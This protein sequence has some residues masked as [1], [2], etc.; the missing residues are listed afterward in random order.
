MAVA[1]DDEIYIMNLLKNASGIILNIL[2]PP[3]IYFLWGIWRGRHW[4]ALRPVHVNESD[5]EVV[6]VDL[7]SKLNE[8]SLIGD[9]AHVRLFFS[10]HLQIMLNV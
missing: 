10:N 4:T 9:M 3:T 7:D 5:T 2:P 8:P 6:W 1:V